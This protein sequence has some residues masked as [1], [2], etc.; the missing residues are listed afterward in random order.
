VRLTFKKVYLKAGGTKT[1]YT[2]YVIKFTC[3]HFSQKWNFAQR[4]L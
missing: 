1:E 2:E 4:F 3:S